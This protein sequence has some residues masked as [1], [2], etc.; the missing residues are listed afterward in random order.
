MSC[1]R[2]FQRKQHDESDSQPPA[3]ALSS[4]PDFAV[5][6]T[7]AAQDVPVSAAPEADPYAALTSSAGYHFNQV[8][9]FAADATPDS[10]PGLLQR[11]GENPPFSAPDRSQVSESRGRNGGT[12]VA[13]GVGG[14]SLGAS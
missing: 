12:A 6:P 13:E 5:S 11:M 9:L 2:T 10:A 1:D 14:Q 3:P 7:P 4:T 8:P